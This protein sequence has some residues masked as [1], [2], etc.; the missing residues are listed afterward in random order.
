MNANRVNVLDLKASCLELVNHPA[1]GS[2]GIGTGENVLVHEKTPGEILVLPCLA[3]T[4]VL[5]EED[6]VVVEHVVDLGEEG[7]EVTDTDVL[8]HLETGNLLVTTLGDGGIAVVEAQDLALLLGNAD[9]AH[10]RVTPGSL[11]AAESDTGN[12]GAVVLTGKTGEGAPTAAKI[13][14]GVALLEIN[15]LADHGKLV[16]LELLEGF[17]LVDI[18][19][20]TRGVDHARAKEPAV[21]VIAAVVVVTDLLLV[22]VG[23]PIG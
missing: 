17:L 9:L 1:K 7:R 10:G 2:R 23:Q 5:E 21:K 6:T 11:V 15:L 18:R 8:R 4:S 12:L 14:H 19:N 20:D 16:V 3:E 13:E 22:W